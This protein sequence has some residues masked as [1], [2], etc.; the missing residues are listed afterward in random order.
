MR[1][2]LCIFLVIAT[3]GGIGMVSAVHAE[4]AGKAKL[5]A[6]G[7]LK[8]D[9]LFVRGGVNSLD[10]PRWAVGGDDANGSVDT[11]TGTVQHSRFWLGYGDVKLSEN[12]ISNFYAEIDLFNL[13]DIPDSLNYNNNQIRFR[14]LYA[15]LIFPSHSWRIGQA[16][17]IFSPLNPTTFNTNGNFWFGGN[18][19]F[20][21]PQ[22]RWTS[23]SGQS[24][25]T[26]QLSVNANLAMTDGQNSGEDFGFPVLM[27][28]LAYGF[29]LAAEK[30]A[31]A[32]LSAVWGK[33]EVDG[34]VDDADQYALGLDLDLPISDQVS[35]K[36][37][38]QSGKNTDTYLFGQGIN[39]TTGNEIGG[40]SGWGQILYR[41]DDRYLL[42]GFLGM[43]DIDGGDLSNGEREGN[44][45]IG[46]NIRYDF[47][48]VCAIGFEYEH[49]N[50]QYKGVSD[51]AADIL[52]FTFI[53]D[54]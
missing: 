16:W 34:L 53:Y 44:T 41:I 10:A 40:T 42:T 49:L 35:F 25:L 50:T 39:L 3:Y 19:G 17:D 51:E 7:W 37:E 43:E 12:G 21:R 13:G 46:A 5:D 9:G 28:R 8:V 45:L 48:K 27:G 6:G 52:W 30:E 26:G 1:K 20:R 2:V 4:E 54:L 33:E 36:G 11:F 15:D 22:V 47:L 14:Q 32:G 29:T 38:V 18:A 23:R 24:N 31:T